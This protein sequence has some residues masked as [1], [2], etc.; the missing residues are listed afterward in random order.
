MNASISRVAVIAL[1]VIF[2]MSGCDDSKSPLSSPEQS[3]AD[4]RLVGAWREVRDKGTVFYHVG[5]LGGKSPEAV[6]RV[7]LV[8]TSDAGELQSPAQTVAF[9]SSIGKARYLN[10]AA[11]DPK[12]IEPLRTE[13]WES[14]EIG[15]YFLMKYE[16]NRE[17][18]EI[19]LWG[20]KDSAKRKAI[21]AGRIQGHI[22]QPGESGT[23]RLTDTSENIAQWV[24][25]E[26]DRLFAEKPLILERVK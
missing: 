14:G 20:M 25:A 6:M 3:E 1:A 2:P 21:E 16:V 18:D 15:S 4:G 13:Q 8:S 9:P 17:G 5:Q 26:G 12:D 10:V 22:K 23:T 24:A 11:M 7:I 19:R